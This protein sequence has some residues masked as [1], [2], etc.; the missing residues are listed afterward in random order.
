MFPTIFGHIP[1]VRLTGAN[2]IANPG[3]E[4]AGGGGADIWANWT[5]TVGDGA[6]ANET[7]L[8][9]K[10]NDAAK[11]TAG[12]TKNTKLDTALITLIPGKKYTLLFWTRGDGTNDGRYQLWDNTNASYI[13]G[14]LSTGITGTTYTAVIKDFTAPVGCVQATLA[15]R[16]SSVDGGIAYFDACEIH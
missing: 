10:G 2:L 7:S 9:H 11:M 1:S 14:I 3:F 8:V 5:E 4:I 13:F 12:A 15:F 6:L 16:C